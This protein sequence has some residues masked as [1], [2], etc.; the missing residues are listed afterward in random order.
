MEK[1]VFKVAWCPTIFVNNHSPFRIECNILSGALCIVVLYHFQMPNTSVRSTSRISNEWKRLGPI[2][3]HGGARKPE[4]MPQTLTLF[5]LIHL[6]I[7]KN[8]QNG[9]QKRLFASLSFFLYYFAFYLF[10]CVN[11]YATSELIVHGK[12]YPLVLYNMVFVCPWDENKATSR[13]W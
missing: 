1:F 11:S 10:V 9:W 4:N 8:R 13:K 5:S 3:E 6:A 12:K 7:M 2:K